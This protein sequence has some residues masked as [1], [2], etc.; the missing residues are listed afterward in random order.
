MF[1]VTNILTELQAGRP[2]SIPTSSN[3]GNFPFPHRV[4]IVSGAHP[5]SIQWVP[6]V[7]R[8]GRETHHSSPSSVLRLR[9]CEAIPPLPNTSLWCG[10]TADKFDAEG[11]CTGGDKSKSTILLTLS[12]LT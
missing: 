10:V 5:A 4:Q 8:P 2:A 9:M 11:I 3:K 1:T 7:K 12:N 6:G